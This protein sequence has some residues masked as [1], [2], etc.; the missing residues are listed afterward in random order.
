MPPE[1]LAIAH[2]PGD[3]IQTLAGISQ[4]WSFDI[5][6]LGM[7]LMEILTGVPLW[8]SLKSRVVR[9][10][11]SVSCKGLLGASGRDP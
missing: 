1:A 2:S 8:M 11:R 5:W 7:I 4:P 3:H 6:S 9:M 10:G